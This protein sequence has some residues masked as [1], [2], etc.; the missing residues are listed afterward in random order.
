MCTNHIIS[1]EKLVNIALDN[2]LQKDYGS[3]LFIPGWND[4]H[5]R[6]Y[7]RHLDS[8]KYQYILALFLILLGDQ[9]ANI[10][11]L[12]S[13]QWE[14]SGRIHCHRGKNRINIILEITIHILLLF[15]V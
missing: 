3:V 2:L 7:R 14:R 6:Q 5:T 9:G 13:N 1:K 4:N 10:Q 15:F 8:G 12:I 11:C